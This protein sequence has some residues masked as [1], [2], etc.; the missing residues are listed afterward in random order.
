[1]SRSE[2]DMEGQWVFSEEIKERG[3]EEIGAKGMI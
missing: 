1:M 2:T 3:T